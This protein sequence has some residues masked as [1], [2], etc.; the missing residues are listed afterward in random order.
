MVYLSSWVVDQGDEVVSSN[1]DQAFAL[2]AVLVALW[3]EF[4][5]PFG[6][7]V[8][9]YFYQLCPYLVPY[10]PVQEQGQSDQDYY[11][12]LGYQYTVRCIHYI[13]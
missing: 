11:R 1:V 4:P 10:Y 8:L 5:A 6:R 12:S 2:A 13:H 7:L 9:A 3:R